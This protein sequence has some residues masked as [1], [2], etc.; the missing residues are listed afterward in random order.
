[1]DARPQPDNILLRHGLPTRTGAARGAGAPSISRSLGAIRAQVEAGALASGEKLPTIRSLAE[2]LAVNRDTVAA[3]YEALAAEGVV[4]ARVGRG[5]FVRGLRSRARAAGPIA[6]AALGARPS[7]CSSS[8]APASP[9]GAGSWRHPLHALKP[10]PRALSRSTRSAARSG[11]CSQDG[12]PRAPLL[13]D[14]QGHL[15]LREVLAE[16]LRAH[17]ILVGPESIVLCQGASQGIALSLR[18]FADVNAAIAVEEPTYPNALAALAALGLG[19][20]PVPM[21]GAGADLDAL[22]RALA[23][24]EVRAF[25]TIPT[26]HNPLG[27]STGSSTGRSCSRWRPATARP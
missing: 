4:D 17:G 22:D 13:R 18:L 1:M 19:A 7:A 23:R 24:S 27:A 8:S 9:Y 12:G 16:R 6:L 25:Y 3:A 21:R 15:G 20:V 10:D 2:H 26:F 11:A 5:T 14:Q